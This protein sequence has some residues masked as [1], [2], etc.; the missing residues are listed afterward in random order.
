MT[1]MTKTRMLGTVLA[2]ILAIAGLMASGVSALVAS[3]HW[4]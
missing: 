3:T 4:G 2:A 1:E